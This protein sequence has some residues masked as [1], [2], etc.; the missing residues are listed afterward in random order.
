MTVLAL[1]TYLPLSELVK[2][3]AVTLTIALIAPSAVALS[4]AGL[5]RRA[6]GSEHSG[7]VLVGTGAGILV[8]LVAA[9]LYALVSR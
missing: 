2:I 3:V 1:S 5:D 8:L 9:G 4:V 6:S 7:A